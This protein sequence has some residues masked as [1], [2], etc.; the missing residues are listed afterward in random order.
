[1]TFRL[2]GKAEPFGRVELGY[3]G[4]GAIEIVKAANRYQGRS[5]VCCIVD[6]IGSH[7]DLSFADTIR[8]TLRAPEK[9][10]TRMMLLGNPGGPCHAALQSRY[11]IPSGYPEP[12]KPVR[13]YSE[14]LQ[15]HVV[16]MTATAASN[17][18]IDLDAYIR[19]LRVACGD[20]PALLDAWLRGRLDVEIGGSFFGSSFS[21]QRSLRDIS[22]GEIGLKEHKAFVV[23]DYGTAAPSVFYLCIPD[24]PGAP[25]GSLWLIDEC[26]ICSNTTGGQRDW[27]RGAYLSTAEQAGAVREWL[28]RWGIS[29]ADIPVVADDAIFNND[30]RPKGS[31]AGDF[32]AAGV[33][34]RR[35]GKMNMREA[36]G[37]AMVRN[38]MQAA[39]RDS[40]TPWLQW[41]RACVGLM[42]PVPTLPRH[43]TDPE[44][45]ANG[46]ANHAIDAV[47]YGV[48]YAKQRS[49]VG[50]TSFRVY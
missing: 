22:P 18:Y 6:E 7:N 20:D 4:V 27:S 35:A 47:R 30:G 33:P 16:F 32:K 29:P 12:G 45:I 40:D 23:F 2:G 25:K 11:G 38:M 26:Y 3:T 43:P 13:F 48:Q 14:D 37:L 15:K 24:P 46:C 50:A 28:E 42:A 21:V 36:N 1:M 10:P 19:S 44:I 17:V 31:V 34:V 41:S 9:V 8:A 39:G 5:Y 49:Y